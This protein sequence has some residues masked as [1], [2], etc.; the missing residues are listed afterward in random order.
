MKAVRLMKADAAKLEKHVR[1]LS[2]EIGV[3][4]AG[5]PQ[6]LRAARY[7]AEEFSQYSPHVTIEEFPVNERYITSEKLE[8]N[9]N[10]KWQGFPC[11]LFSSAP[12]T[13]GKVIRAELVYFD[14]AT[15]YQRPDLSFLTEKAVVH[16]GCHIE[17]E[18]NYQR[19]M[20]A[21]PAFILFVDTRYTGTVQ[22]AD[23]LFPAYVKKYGAVPS[24]NVAYMDAWKW[25][26]GKAAEARVQAAGGIRKST[27]TA[28]VCEIKGTDPDAGVI[29]AGGHHDTQAGTVGADDNAIGSAAVLELAR[30]LSAVPHKRTFKLISFGAEEQL[31]VGSA[32]YARK[33]RVEIEKNGVFMCNFDSF[34]S[35][36]G[37]YEMTI[38]A[39]DAMCKKVA[40]IL[41][42]NDLWYV[43]DH[44][45]CPFTDQFPFAACRVPGFWLHRK[46]CATGCFYHHRSDDTLDKIGFATAAQAVTGVA[47]LMTCLADMEDISAL[48]GIP[49]E[50]QKLVSSLFNTISGGF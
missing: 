30:I 20:A 46:N 3:R 11:S 15:G 35:A 27:T 31:S 5:S 32:E 4:L 44:T 34:G 1:T 18:T 38:N 7:I 8:V 47:E 23:G 2:E 6:E 28:V 48:R 22:L 39:T 50:Q 14:T 40:E 10:G 19:L 49:E 41:H 21:K 25:L 16:L 24:F 42:K 43:A 13:D 29:Y 26:Q 37:W 36:L 45:P 9:V 12:S 17:N 33:H